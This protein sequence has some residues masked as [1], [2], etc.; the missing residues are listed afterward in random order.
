MAGE[1]PGYEP[2][3]LLGRLVGFRL[4]SVQFVIDYV[5]L[6]FDG[7]TQDTPILNCDVMPTVVTSGRSFTDGFPGYA[8][9]LRSLI[10]GTVVRTEEAT[11]VGLRIELDSGSVVVN[12]ALDELIGP[13]I[14]MLSG[15]TDG[16]WMCWR[17][18]E[19]CFFA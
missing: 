13:E 19:D 3:E 16:H 17:P 5:Q 11:G 4:Y 1:S 12:P 8:E 15:F 10:S 6:H 9:A 2:N 14:A 7:P 18:G